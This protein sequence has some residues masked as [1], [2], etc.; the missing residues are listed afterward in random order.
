MPGTAL[1]RQVEEGSVTLLDPME[2]LVGLR[3]L[4][5]GLSVDNL[6]NESIEFFS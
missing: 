1:H 2:T 6:K 3:M 5:D 4:I